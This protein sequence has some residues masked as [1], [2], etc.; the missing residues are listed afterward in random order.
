MYTGLARGLINK[1]NLWGSQEKISPL[2]GWVIQSAKVVFSLPLLLLGEEL[3]LQGHTK[4]F[5]KGL[6]LLEVLLV[7]ALVLDLGLDTYGGF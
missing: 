7:L 2:G 1:K 6:E 3:L 5:T 4:L